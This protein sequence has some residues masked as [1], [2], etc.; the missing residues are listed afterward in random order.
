M[1]LVCNTMMTDEIYLILFEVLF[2]RLVLFM[3]DTSMSTSDCPGANRNFNINRNVQQSV[4]S[5]AMCKH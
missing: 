2:G 3:V 5:I 4:R 1:V